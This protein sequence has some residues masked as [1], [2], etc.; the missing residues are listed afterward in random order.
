MVWVMRPFPRTSLTTRPAPAR[1]PRAGVAGVL[2]L[3]PLALA[4]CPSSSIAFDSPSPLHRALAIAEADPATDPA[5]LAG[6]IAALDSADPA[7][8]LI[9]INRLEA[10]TGQR[11]GYR[12]EASAAQRAGALERWRTWYEGQQP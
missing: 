9:A 8:R 10:I 1:R 11:F 12:S 7:E 3:M 4:G 2:G 6:L 5:A